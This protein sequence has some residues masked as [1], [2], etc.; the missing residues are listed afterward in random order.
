MPDAAAGV[1]FAS[2]AVVSA[3]A[4]AV[5]RAVYVQLPMLTAAADK[6][7][8]WQSVLLCAFAMSYMTAEQ[9]LLIC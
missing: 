9:Q 6:P 7:C 4:A 3:A 5:G 1:A 2:D 8:C